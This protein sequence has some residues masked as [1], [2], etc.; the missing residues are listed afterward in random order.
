MA[1]CTHDSRGRWSGRISGSSCNDLE[2][3]SE[4]AEEGGPVVLAPV[5]AHSAPP[6]WLRSYTCCST[7]GRCPKYGIGA[8][9]SHGGR[10]SWAPSIRA[11][12]VAAVEDESNGLCETPGFDKEGGSP[13]SAASS[14][15]GWSC[16]RGSESR[17]ASCPPPT[18]ARSSSSRCFSA[19][20]SSD[21]SPSCCRRRSVSSCLSGL[22]DRR[23]PYASSKSRVGD[24]LAGVVRGSPYSP[25]DSFS[26]A[27]RAAGWRLAALPRRGS[28]AP[29]INSGL[30]AL[31][32]CRLWSK[33]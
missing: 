25:M 29:S 3:C 30:L 32:R 20:T 14:C 10:A 6:S 2:P 7:I 9:T 24:D 5:I 15:G 27:V 11:S 12:V 22:P 1:A 4:A 28:S 17:C 18:S 8:G 31:A 23:L 21:S 26:A 13:S 16:L 19:T 33:M